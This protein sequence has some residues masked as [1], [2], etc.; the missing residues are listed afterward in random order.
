MAISKDLRRKFPALQRG[1]Y[2][3]TPTSGPFNEDLLEWRQNHDLDFLV[4]ASEVTGDTAALLEKTRTAVAKFFN[5]QAADV[6]LVP[7]FSQGLNLLL[8]GLNVAERVLLL[9]DD[10]PSLNWPFESR[11]FPITY[12][13]ISEQLEDA[14][15]AC[16]QEQKITVFAFSAVQWLNGYKINFNFIKRLRELYPNLLLIMDGTQFCGTSHFD[17]DASGI[18]VMGASGYK[19][20]LS[21]YG[22]GFMLVHPRHQ[23]RFRLKT[24]GYGSG[25]NAAFQKNEGTFCMQLEPG[26]LDP[27]C[28]GSLLF[29]LNFLMD[30]GLS[31]ITQQNTKLA[32][33][34]KEELKA[35]ELLDNTIVNHEPLSTIFRLTSKD[36]YEALQQENVVCAIRGGGIR[37]GFHFYNTEDEV[38]RIVEILKK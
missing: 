30:V 14:I 24:R 10:Y 2:V 7:S 34:L 27:L 31:E 21:G 8:E 22:N 26:H 4:G 28:F 6:A 23:S 35:L 15:E 11:G 29:S 5:F 25:R 3:N 36:K 20:L 17:F 13:T 12:L 19:W 16:I 18:D 32:R 33:L 37:M 1:I 38:K 9:Q